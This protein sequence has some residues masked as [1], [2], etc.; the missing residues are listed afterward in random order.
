LK[1]WLSLVTGLVLAFI[2]SPIIYGQETDCEKVQ[3]KVKEELTHVSC[4]GGNDGRVV[5]DISGGSE[6]YSLTL[7]NNGE[8][9][10]GNSIEQL[11]AGT[12]WL[13]ITDINNCEELYDFE[14]S[15]PE[16]YEITI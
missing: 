16:F 4:Y 8:I 1:R 7:Q 2:Y 14:I 15:E 5:L 11:G 10:S 6:P 13:R 9:F 12:Y 3:F